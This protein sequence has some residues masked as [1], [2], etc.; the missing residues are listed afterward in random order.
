MDPGGRPVDTEDPYN[1]RN[2]KLFSVRAC[3][4]CGTMFSYS[5]MLNEWAYKDSKHDRA[6]TK[7]YFCSWGCLCRYRNERSVAK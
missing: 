5:C 2:K 4:Q 7:V 6:R 1:V 3:D